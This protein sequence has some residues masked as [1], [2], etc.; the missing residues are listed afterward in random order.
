[1]ASASV[2]SL[3]VGAFL[4]SLSKAEID[5]M[6]PA[7]LFKFVEYVVLY[8]TRS[9]SLNSHQL[10]SVPIFSRSCDFSHGQYGMSLATT[11]AM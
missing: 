11:N 4:S 10:S 5:S 1:M 3:W 7:E 2:S 9:V 8:E 6:N